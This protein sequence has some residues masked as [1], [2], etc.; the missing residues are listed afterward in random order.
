MDPQDL[1]PL[2]Q[3]VHGRGEQRRLTPK[4]RLPGSLAAA[5]HGLDQGVQILRV[6]DV[7]ESRQVVDLW[8]R[9]NHRG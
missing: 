7:R 9:L 3:G 8:T 6:H 1:H 5:M 2:V 4:E